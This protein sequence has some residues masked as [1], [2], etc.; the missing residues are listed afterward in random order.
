MKVGQGNQKGDSMAAEIE[1]IFSGRLTCIDGIEVDNRAEIYINEYYQGEITLYGIPREAAIAIHDEKY[2]YL[3]IELECG[4]TLSVLGLSFISSV[5]NGSNVFKIKV[6]GKILLKSEKSYTNTSKFLKIKF[7]ITDGNELIGL[8]PYDLNKNHVDIQMYRNINIPIQIKTINV[9]IEKGE[10]NFRVIP[11]YEYSKESFSIGFDHFI[12][13]KFESAMDIKQIRENLYVIA[14]FF[15]I[16]AGEIVT[17]NSLQ[18]IEEDRV[19]DVIGICNFPKNKLNFS[20]NKLDTIAFKRCTLYKVSDFEDLKHALNYWFDN[21]SKIYNA[22]QAY[23]RILLDEDVNVVT[24][25]KYLAAMQLI[26]GYAQAYTDEEKEVRE[27]ELK[28]NDIINKIEN[29]DEKELIK[30]GLGFSGISF[31]RAVKDYLHKGYNCFEVISKNKL[32]NEKES[33]IQNIV[34][35]RNYYTH[36]SNRMSAVM[37][38]EDLM[39]I[40]SLCKKLYRIISLQDM[41]FNNQ[42]IKLRSQYDRELCNLLECIL[43]IKIHWNDMNF[44]EFDSAMR[45][46]SDSK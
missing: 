19:I 34:E 42:L 20:Q 46:F 38:F 12:T 15:S 17:V 24:I 41:G 2:E 22:Q 26:E 33:L 8:C 16:L 7:K 44:T 11:Q 29:E 28:K 9:Q 45:W 31:M 37:K 25:N 23:R 39:N 21:Y 14:D 30:K 43:E 4:E 5:G 32:S 35:A 40:A 3:V 27:F 36:S 18:F 13:W 6:L 1:K 10:L